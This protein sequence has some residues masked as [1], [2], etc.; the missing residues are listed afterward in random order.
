MLLQNSNTL[1]S[2]Q[3]LIVIEGFCSPPSAIRPIEVFGPCRCSPKETR[4]GW[5]FFHDHTR[6][7]FHQPAILVLSHLFNFDRQEFLVI[8][9][10]L[11]F[12]SL[13]RPAMVVVII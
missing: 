7:C 11:F 12:R 1:Y 13:I 3:R 2:E 5:C 6:K 9:P 8:L 4:S 10:F